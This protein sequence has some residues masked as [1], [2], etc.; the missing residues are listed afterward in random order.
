[1]PQKKDLVNMDSTAIEQVIVLTRRI[2]DLEKKMK[3][4]DE[5]RIFQQDVIP[6]AIKMRAMG[7]ANRY[8]MAGLEANRPEGFS[9]TDSVTAYFA[10]DTNKLWIWNGT[11]WKSATLS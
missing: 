4:V 5:K 1:M 3:S 9:V 10:T 2:E 8:I 7:E 11:S 6:G